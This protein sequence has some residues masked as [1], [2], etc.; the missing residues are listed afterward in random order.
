M[1][2]HAIS[3]WTLILWLYGL[4]T[5][6]K[7]CYF[8]AHTH[9]KHQAIVTSKAI[10]EPIYT[11]IFF[12]NLLKPCSS[13]VLAGLHEQLI[14]N[15]KLAPS[16]LCVCERAED[17]QKIPRWCSCSTSLLLLLR[18]FLLLLLSHVFSL[19]STTF[20]EWMRF[21]TSLKEKWTRLYVRKDKSTQTITTTGKK[22]HSYTHTHTHNVHIFY[23]KDYAR[24]TATKL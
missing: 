4:T 13:L 21:K 9:T 2:S 15:F 23:L 5:K 19:L 20:C 3:V 10:P 17:R 16:S 18:F 14:N 8:V 12:Y 22:R 6:A 24:P 7:I 1:K 11:W